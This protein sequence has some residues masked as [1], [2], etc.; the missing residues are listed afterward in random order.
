M[1]NAILAIIIVAMVTI[2]IVIA[3]NRPSADQEAIDYRQALM[4][5]IDGQMAPLLLMQQ[6]QAPFNAAL[7]RAHAGHLAVLAGMIPEAFAR[8]TSTNRKLESAALPYVWS[9]QADFLRGVQRFQA[10]A[11]AL[12]RTADSGEQSALRQA[13]GAVNAQCDQCHRSFRSG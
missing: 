6:G 7:L 8:N 5:V 10:S 3:R 2:G 11:E 9:D 4:T 13:I 12:R 1:K